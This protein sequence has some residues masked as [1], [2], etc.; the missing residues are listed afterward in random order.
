MVISDPLR[1]IYCYRRISNIVATAGQP[2]S[3]QFQAIA[4]GGFEIDINLGLKDA[5][6]ALPD[7]QEQAEPLGL[8][9]NLFQCFGNSQLSM[10]L[11]NL[12]TTCTVYNGKSSLLTMPQISE[13]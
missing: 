6:Y 2:T 11:S 4:A 7:E 10:I 5:D 1:E 13:F 9:T 8:M 12:Q 3:E